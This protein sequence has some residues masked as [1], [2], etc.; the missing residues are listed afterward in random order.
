MVMSLAAYAG[1]LVV[2]D[3]ADFAE[4]ARDRPGRPLPSGGVSRRGALALAI[5][6]LAVALGAAA[7][8]SAPLLVLAALLIAEIL[9]YNLLAKKSA[10]FGPVAM[11]LCRGLSVLAGAAALGP[12][13]PLALAAAAAITLYIIAVSTL[14]R[15]ETRDPCIPP[16]IGQLIRGLLFIQAGFCI[17]ARGSGWVAA[18]LLLA[19]WPVSRL[20]ASR[21]YGS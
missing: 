18:V 15:T 9:W 14:A 2:N 3:L 8:V 10:F 19:L 6:L 13:A 1:G 11:G 21:F 20:V 16:L 4:D 12:P 7:L 17:A 5:L